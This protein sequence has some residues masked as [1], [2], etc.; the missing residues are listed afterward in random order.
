MAL[1]AAA[2]RGLKLRPKAGAAGTGHPRSH[3]GGKANGHK[4]VGWGLSGH[5][6]GQAGA[7]AGA[8]K[9]LMGK[10]ELLAK[11]QKLEGLK[12]GLG[13]MK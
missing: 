12:L 6:D 9:S 1:A 2:A 10:A 7:A 11:R 8:K 3:L 13:G 5:A 4:G